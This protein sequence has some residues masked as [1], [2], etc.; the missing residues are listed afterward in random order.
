MSLDFKDTARILSEF[1]SKLTYDQIPQEAIETVKMYIADYYAACFAG[2]KVNRKFNEAM[3][4]IVRGMSGVGDSS[5][6]ELDHKLPVENAA[7]MNAVYAH[8]ADMDDG[9]RKAMGHVAAHV[10]SAV[11]ALAESLGDKSWEDVLTAIMIG[12]EIYNRVG[13]MAQPGLVHRGFHSTGTA[14]AVACGAAC[15]KLMG[16]DADGIYDALGI[17]A[18][19]ASGLIII[20]ESGQSCKPLNPANAA[21]TGIISAKLATSGVNGPDLPLE[22]KKGWFQAMTDEVHYEMLEGLGQVFTIC[23]SYLKPY[24]SCR[25]THCGIEAAIHIRD[26]MHE[27]RLGIKD[28]KSLKLYIYDNAIQIAGKIKIPKTSDNAK[29]SIHY[30]LAVAMT[31]GNYTL[32]DLEKEPTD[33]VREIVEKIELI[34]DAKMEDTASGIRGSMLV[35]EFEDGSSIER[36]VLL[37]KGDAANPFSWDDMRRKLVACMQ[38]FAHEPDALA[39]KIRALDFSKQYNGIKKLLE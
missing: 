18:I 22:S 35:A 7:F 33:D 39:E 37:P 34:P 5:V 10:M 2:I 8:G 31:T 27:K 3:L 38:G 14:G 20:A 25:H 26:E 13:A 23:E 9:N 16:L 4:G 1:A 11:F 24:P 32:D 12:Y 17:A 15:A 6:F 28:I 30:S 19:Q 29:F 36:T 21:K